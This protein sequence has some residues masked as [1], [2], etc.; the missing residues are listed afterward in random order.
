MS[1]ISFFNETFGQN[2]LAPTN[3]E[4]SKIVMTIQKAGS[5][6]HNAGDSTNTTN[7]EL[8]IENAGVSRRGLFLS[9]CEL[10]VNK[11]CHHR[12]DIDTGTAREEGSKNL[13]WWSVA[14][15]AMAFELALFHQ[16]DCVDDLNDPASPRRQGSDGRSLLSDRLES[17]HEPLIDFELPFGSELRW[18]DLRLESMIGKGSFCTVRRARMA[19]MSGPATSDSLKRHDGRDFYAVKCLKEAPATKHGEPHRTVAA[20]SDQDA[21]ILTSATDL[22]LEAIVLSRLH[23]ENIVKL[24]GTASLAD[25]SQTGSFFLVM[26]LLTETLDQRLGIWARDASIAA[27]SLRT[28]SA[29]GLLFPSATARREA[30]APDA[31]LERLKTTALGIAK[32]LNYLH[33]QGLVYQDLKPENVGFDG[34]G[35]VKLFDFGFARPVQWLETHESEVA[36]SLRYQAPEQAAS[37]LEGE[38][39][40]KADV[41]SFAIVLW[42]ICT[43]EKPFRQIK[44]VNQ[45]R[46]RVV[47]GRLRPSLYSLEASSH[48]LCD[49]LDE[50]WSPYP[51]ER[52]TLPIVL[53]RLDRIFHELECLVQAG[54]GDSSLSLSKMPSFSP[55]KRLTSLDRRSSGH[56]RNHSAPYSSHDSSGQQGGHND[57]SGDPNLLRRALS[58]LKRQP[59]G[60]A[61][62]GES[63][64]EKGV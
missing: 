63:T 45:F 7:K 21:S 50:S 47:D 16:E 30:M 39:C 53:Q 57:H 43:L 32:A 25:A 26:E 2:S 22:A 13:M 46:K 58:L 5:S 34:N 49:L 36:G 41:Y 20:S 60:T 62:R 51:S 64:V 1:L 28:S 18:E 56:S 12:D 35:K 38:E 15:A 59:G 19:V 33:E 23:H 29:A 8:T 6:K 31:M 61:E 3:D 9:S 10:T 55:L 52:P 24:Y 4:A 48:S 44:K 54:V 37:G 27:A 11:G 14:Q 40:T 42:Q 17:P